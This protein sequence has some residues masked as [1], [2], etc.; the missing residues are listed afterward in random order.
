MFLAACGSATPTAPSTVPPLPAPG[1]SLPN[2]GI[3]RGIVRIER[4]DCASCGN[5]RLS[6]FVLRL[7]SS[8][9][10]YAGNLDVANVLNVDLS[11]QREADGGLSLSPTRTDFNIDPFRV[12]P[13]AAAG[14]LGALTYRNTYEAGRVTILSAVLIGPISGTPPFEGRWIGRAVVTSCV[15]YCPAFSSPRPTMY[16]RLELTQEGDRIRGIGVFDTLVCS[17]DIALDGRVAGYDGSMSGAFTPT[18][19]TDQRL[20]RLAAF[21]A[22]TTAVGEMR[23]HLRLEGRAPVFI[24]NEPSGLLSYEVE[25]DILYL[26][27]QF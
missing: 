20:F 15:G 11:G 13:D 21:A 25:A 26:L 4:I 22:T 6:E 27:R 18:S 14:L 9:G 5:Q 8:G 2:Q 1:G 23:G 7:S 12:T 19:V 10:R 17:C 3:W 24:P 16:V